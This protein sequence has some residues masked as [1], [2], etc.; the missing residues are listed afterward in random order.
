[1]SSRDVRIMCP[2]LNCRASSPPSVRG[3]RDDQLVTLYFVFPALL[4]GEACF[5]LYVLL[6]RWQDWSVAQPFRVRWLSA[7]SGFWKRNST[8]GYFGL[9]H[10]VYV[11]TVSLFI[12][13]HPCFSIFFLPK[14]GY[15]PPQPTGDFSY[16]VI[17]LVL[18]NMMLRFYV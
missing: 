2:R 18:A 15:I 1:M 3:D 17:S 4:A 5:Y 8:R 12:I 7:L 6:Q 11:T 16:H 10:D 9:V 13:Y 14:C